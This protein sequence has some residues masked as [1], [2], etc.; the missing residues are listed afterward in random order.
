[1][2]E[3]VIMNPLKLLWSFHERIGRGATLALNR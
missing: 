3:T 1:M 2:S